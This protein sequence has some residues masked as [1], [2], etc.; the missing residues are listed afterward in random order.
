MVPQSFAPWQVVAFLLGG[1]CLD[2]KNIALLII[3]ED[4]YVDYST[5]ENEKYHYFY[6]KDLVE[7]SK[8]FNDLCGNCNFDY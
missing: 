2:L 3:Y 5:V 8:R 4:G 1:D 6:Y 7:S